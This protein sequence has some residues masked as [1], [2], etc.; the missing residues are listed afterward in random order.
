MNDDYLWNKTGEPDV[1]LKRLEDVLGALRY[2]P[3]SFV[4]PATNAIVRRRYF[5]SLAAAAAIVLMLLAAGLWFAFHRQRAGESRAG[6][7]HSRTSN[8]R[9]AGKPTPNQSPAR[10]PQPEPEQIVQHRSTQQLPPRH[11]FAASTRRSDST[12]KSSLT[13]SERAEAAVA[14]TQLMLALRLA[15]AKLNLAQRKTLTPTPINIRN[16]HKVG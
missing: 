16:Q 15:S 7:N 1:E 5:R 8:G 2:R 12:V 6:I 11:R 9:E 10:N 14:R 4:V 13:A 3:K